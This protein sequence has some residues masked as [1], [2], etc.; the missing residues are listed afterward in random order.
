MFESRPDRFT[1]EPDW[2]F[3]PNRISVSD[4]RFPSRGTICPSQPFSGGHFSFLGD[5]TLDLN[6]LNMKNNLVIE[7]L[8]YSIAINKIHVQFC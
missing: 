2:F 8:T 6:L 5:T 3:I 7:L 4:L 1:L